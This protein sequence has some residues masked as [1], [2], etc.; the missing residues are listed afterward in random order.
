[1]SEDPCGGGEILVAGPF[2]PPGEKYPTRLTLPSHWVPGDVRVLTPAADFL[3]NRVLLSAACGTLL[4]WAPA[5]L[6]LAPGLQGDET[7]A[8]AALAAAATGRAR[9]LVVLDRSPWAHPLA[10]AVIR[11]ARP[12]P[13]RPSPWCCPLSVFDLQVGS[14]RALQP[15]DVPLDRLAAIMRRLLGPGGCPWGQEAAA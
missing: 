8:A 2:A 4:P 5:P 11:Q 9:V 6:E 15:S 10:W 1:M 7:L 13:E 3:G 14:G 12:S